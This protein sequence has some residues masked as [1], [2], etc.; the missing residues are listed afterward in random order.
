MVVTVA[1]GCDDLP[2]HTHIYRTVID[3]KT[4]YIDTVVD[5]FDVR[6]WI[7]WKAIARELIVNAVEGD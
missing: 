7:D 4:Q 3:E 5:E 2:P 1:C 6:I